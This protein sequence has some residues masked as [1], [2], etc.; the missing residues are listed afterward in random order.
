[1]EKKISEIKEEF[2]R[3]DATELVRLMES[4]S[5]D[6]R[7]GVIGLLAKYRKKLDA[8]EKE[9]KRLWEMASY[10]RQYSQYEWICGI[11]EAGR[12]PLAGPVTAGA[13]ILPK[14]VEILYLNDSKKLSPGKREALF[15]KGCGMVG[16]ICK[17]AE[18]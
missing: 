18:N 13:V 4:Y 12:G 16:G 9:Q 2:D 14:D 1:M 5:Q 17:P 7:S 11:D 10:E 15:G 6:P 8:L 3:A